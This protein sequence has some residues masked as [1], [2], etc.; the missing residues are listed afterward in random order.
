MNYDHLLGV[1]ANWAAILTAVVATT[2]YG[3]YVYN[4]VAQRRALENY[5]RTEKADGD[6]AG[7]RTVLNLMAQ[8]SL[9]ESEVLSAAFRSTKV[10]PAVSVDEKGRA[11]IL[12]F[13]YT[14]SDLPLPNKF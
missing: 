13:E 9:T 4:Q 1:I 11:D 12:M 8:L 3:R 7:M 6:D 5:L 14:G 2:A 10:N